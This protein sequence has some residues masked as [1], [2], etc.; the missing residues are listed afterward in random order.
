MH[1]GK[2]NSPPLRG[3]ITF[4]NSM[5]GVPTLWTVGLAGIVAVILG[6]YLPAPY[7]RITT[8][9]RI[10]CSISRPSLASRK[11][12]TTFI[13]SCRHVHFPHCHHC[14]MCTKDESYSYVME[15][16]VHLSFMY[17]PYVDWYSLLQPSARLA[18]VPQGLRHYR[19][20]FLSKWLT[21]NTTTHNLNTSPL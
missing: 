19:G 17:E 6:C 14:L 4:G 7:F 13:G 2:E 11:L 8:R 16:P 3:N 20:R 1:V 5:L 12:F 9:Y 18:R 10:T 21:P 15:R